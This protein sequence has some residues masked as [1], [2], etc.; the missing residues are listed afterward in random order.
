MASQEV[1][2]KV[3]PCLRG[4]CNTIC[5]NYLRDASATGG[6]LFDPRRHVGFLT[7]LHESGRVA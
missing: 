5:V 1:T 4:A 2:P 6:I 3:T 7:R